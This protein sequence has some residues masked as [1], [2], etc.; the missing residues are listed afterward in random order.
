MD[1]YTF[2]HTHDEVLVIM[3]HVLDFPMGIEQ[4]QDPMGAQLEG[5]KPY[6]FEQ[7]KKTESYQR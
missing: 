3:I 5:N 6:Y 7:F 4:M 2:F 1:T